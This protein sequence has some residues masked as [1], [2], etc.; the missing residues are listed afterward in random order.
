MDITYCGDMLCKNVSQRFLDGAVKSLTIRDP[1]YIEQ[2]RR[3]PFNPTIDEFLYLFES[4]D[5]GL[6]VPRGF[7]LGNEKSDLVSDERVSVPVEYPDLQLDLSENQSNAMEVFRLDKEKPSGCFMFVLPPGEGKTVLGASLARESGERTLVLSH[8]GVILDGWRKD[9]AQTLGKQN[10]G[11]I[12]GNVQ[13][14]GD[15][16][17]LASLQ[18]IWNRQS[19][20]KELFKL[21]GMVI[22]D[23]CHI[24]PART[25][26]PFIHDCPAKYKVA[27]TAAVKRKDRMHSIVLHEFGNPVYE[28]E[29][30]ERT[31]PLLRVV[32][33]M[34]KFATPPTNYN[35]F[36]DELSS[37]IFRN[38]QI[39]DD[40]VDEIQRGHRCLI[41]C[42]RRAQVFALKQMLMYRGYFTWAM[43]GGVDEVRSLERISSGQIRCV[44]GTM[45]YTGYGVNMKPLDT[46]FFASPVKAADSSRMQFDGEVIQFVGRVQREWRNKESA[47]VYYY[48]DVFHR[49]GFPFVKHYNRHLVP[50]FKKLGCEDAHFI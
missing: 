7:D 15:L 28:M 32:P 19:D 31:V 38:R 10:V 11:L 50:A 4:R 9:I 2:K 40:V 39:V 46:L 27:L 45:S 36:L 18:T 47:S 6:A 43:V 1:R 33:Q 14:I 49:H 24:A 8:R 16:V 22:L 5:G 26:L 23:E 29:D 30:R 20:W 42:R 13:R 37:D 17:T 35:A 25:F 21:F 12:K 48:V 41:L 44:V 34:T 3:S